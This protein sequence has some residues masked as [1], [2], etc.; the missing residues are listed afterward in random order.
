M[1]AFVVMTK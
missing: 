1:E